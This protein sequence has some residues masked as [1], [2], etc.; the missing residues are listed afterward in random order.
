MLDTLIALCAIQAQEKVHDKIPDGEAAVAITRR[1]LRDLN[2]NGDLSLRTLS[3]YADPAK[4]SRWFVCLDSDKGPISVQLDGRT[5]LALYISQYTPN[6][7][8]QMAYNQHPTPES[9]ERAKTML[10]RL[11]YDR[12]VTLEARSGFSNAASTATFYRKLHGLTFF[13]MNPTYG[14]LLMFDPDTGAI[15]YFNPSP[16]LPEVNAWKPRV[17]GQAALK[18]INLWVENRAQQRHRDLKLYQRGKQKAELGYWKFKEEA[19]ARLVWR[20]A[21]FVEIDGMPYSTGAR[22]VMVDA[23]TGDLVEK[24]DPFTRED[25]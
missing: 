24:D 6:P 22:D 15:H 13:N 10:H 5:G 1:L 21:S 2:V 9:T 4:D 17:S 14:N 25:R 3:G 8:I 11:G 18:K 7:A 12:D 16:P 19:K 23:V 20:S